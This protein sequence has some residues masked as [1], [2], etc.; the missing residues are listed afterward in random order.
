MNVNQDSGPEEGKGLK[1]KERHIAAHFQYVA[2]VDEE[3]VPLTQVRKVREINAL[4]IRMNTS[5]VR[6]GPQGTERI[7]LDTR[8]A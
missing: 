4:D 3:D 1:I 6:N 8:D 7:R 5:N 2:R